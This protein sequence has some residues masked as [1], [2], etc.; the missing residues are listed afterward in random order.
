MK[1]L[2]MLVFLELRWIMKSLN[3]GLTRSCPPIL[4]SAY[5]VS[6]VPQQS[7]TEKHNIQKKNDVLNFKEYFLKRMKNMLL[8]WI[9]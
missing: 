3:D 6:E 1:L 7:H 2:D 8:L 4:N 5:H 9:C